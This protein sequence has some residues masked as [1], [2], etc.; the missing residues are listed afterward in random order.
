M[1]ASQLD[2]MRRV[3]S[4]VL[5]AVSA[6]DSVVGAPGGVLYAGLMSA[7]CSLQQF[8][9]IMGGLTRAGLLEKDGECYTLTP[10]GRRHLEAAERKTA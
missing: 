8:T 7:G 3:C 6:A 5:E 4:I 2:A 10:A 1:T 9:G